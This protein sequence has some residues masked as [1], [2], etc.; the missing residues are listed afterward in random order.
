SPTLGDSLDSFGN[1]ECSPPVTVGGKE[2]KFGRVIWG[3][4]ASRPM[5]PEVTDFLEAQ[6]VQGAFSID[7]SWLDVGHIDE[8]ISFCLH[9]AAA[10]KFKLLI[11][12]A[13]EAVAILRRMDAG[14]EGSAT[15]TKPGLKTVSAALASVS[16]MDVQTR[17]QAKIDGVETTLRAKLG[18]DAADVIK[19]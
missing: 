6:V 11:A 4:D 3:H 8:I 1:L 12:S 10:K 18:L 7:T 5:Q 19:I 13:A 17:V 14:G 15:F 9:P 16:Y 2:W